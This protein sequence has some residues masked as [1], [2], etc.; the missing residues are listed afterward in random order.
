[1]EWYYSN[2]T[3]DNTTTNDRINDID[4][5]DDNDN[6][7]NGNIVIDNNEMEIGK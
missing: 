5:D 3:E 7:D 1:M 6:N 2:L 4:N